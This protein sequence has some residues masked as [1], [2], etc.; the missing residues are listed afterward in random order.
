M[1]K[2]IEIAAFSA[3]EFLHNFIKTVNAV[4]VNIR[5]W[6]HID[7]HNFQADDNAV[8]IIFPSFYVK[9]DALIVQ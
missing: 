3:H 5:R 9:V 4:Y 2:L 8:I 1:L 7:F 6:L